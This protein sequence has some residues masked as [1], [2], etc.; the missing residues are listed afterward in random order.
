LRG[1]PHADGYYERIQHRTIRCCSPRSLPCN[2]CY[3]IRAHAAQS[4]TRRL[5]RTR[6][7]H[8][9]AQIQIHIL[10]QAPRRRGNPCSENLFAGVPRLQSMESARARLEEISRSPSDAGSI[11]VFLRNSVETFTLT[12]HAR[13][14]V[15]ACVHGLL[16][17]TRRSSSSSHAS[18]RGNIRNAKSN[19][20]G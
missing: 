4:R 17:V 8:L 11:K 13:P 12:E 15:S 1:S 19:E 20:D 9:R 5:R 18:V 7:V 2:E 3:L 16:V 14:S 10:A 6:R